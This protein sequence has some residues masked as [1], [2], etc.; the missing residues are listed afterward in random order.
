M[1]ALFLPHLISFGVAMKRKLGERANVDKLPARNGGEPQQNCQ[2]KC[3]AACGPERRRVRGGNDTALA[4][5]SR[6]GANLGKHEKGEAR[7]RDGSK[8]LNSCYKFTP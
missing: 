2:T 4:G 6:A 1:P 8:N 3:G 7:H 5:A